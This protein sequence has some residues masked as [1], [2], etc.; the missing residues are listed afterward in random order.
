MN[1]LQL[2]D[3]ITTLFVEGYFL[4]EDSVEDPYIGINSAQNYILLEDGGYFVMEG[5]GILGSYVLPNGDETPAIYVVGKYRVPAEWKVKGLEVTIQETAI[6]SPS[7]MV[8]KMQNK[9]QWRVVMVDYNTSSTNLSEAADRLARRFPDAR[10]SF[11]RGVGEVYGRYVAD[12]PDIEL[13][14]LYPPS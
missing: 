5:N 7:A 10:L 13:L 1:V 2:R 8:G 3:I 12:I 11:R 4:Q 9:K 6:P 14:T